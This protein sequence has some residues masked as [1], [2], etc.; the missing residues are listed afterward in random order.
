ME[1]KYQGIILN[2]KDVGET[3]R[4]YIIYT[5]ETGKIRVLAKGVKKSRAKLAGYL[6]PITKAEIFIAK[7]KGLGKITGSIVNDNFPQ[8]KSNLGS[9]KQVFYVFKILERIISEQDK[10]EKSFNLL[11]EYL[12]IMEKLSSE[13]NLKNENKKNIITFGFLFK[14]L[15]EFGYRVE[16]GKC[17]SCEKRLVSEKNFFSAQRGGIICENCASSGDRKIKISDDS[18]KLIRIFLKNKIASLI[19]IEA[20]IKDSNQIKIIFTDFL[21]WAFG[22]IP[23]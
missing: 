16:V 22:S 13:E 2:K 10:D 5:F 20:S 3:D 9:M 4:I 21:S 7:T 18:I 11:E 12:Q 17:V 23:K 6:E 19:K 1:Y 14:F 15:D 8:I